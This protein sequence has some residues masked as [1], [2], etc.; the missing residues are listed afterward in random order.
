[1]EEHPVVSAWHASGSEWMGAISIRHFPCEGNAPRTVIN[2]RGNM[3]AKTLV[4]QEM[5]ARGQMWTTGWTPTYAH[6]DADVE[7]AL[8][9]ADAAL[10]ILSEHRDNPAE[11]VVGPIVGE[12]FRR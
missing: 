8:D 5:W 12:V 6:T 1:M 3:S 11:V 9:A 7:R 2:W 10:T 4:Q